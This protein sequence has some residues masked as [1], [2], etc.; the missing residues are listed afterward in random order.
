MLPQ[1]AV[2]G[3]TQTV[4]FKRE[5]PKQASDLAKEIAAFAT[6]NAGMILLGVEDDGEIV[7]VPEALDDVG[8]RT[9]RTRLEGIFNIVRPTIAPGIRFALFEGKAVA[10]IEVPKGPQ[11]IYYANS[12]P[13]HRLLTAARPMF[14]DDVI[15]AVLSWA[16]ERESGPSPESLF[17]GELA[18]F[19]PQVD[20]TVTERQLPQLN[21]WA[22][23]LRWTA[24]QQADQARQLAASAPVEMEALREPLLNLAAA[25]NTIAT[26]R[27]R[28]GAPDLDVLQAVHDAEQIVARVQASYLGLGRFSASIAKQQRTSLTTQARL[29]DDLVRRID[30]SSGSISAK[31]VQDETHQRGETLFLVASLGVGIG[32]EAKRRELREIAIEL[33]AI[34]QL[35]IY[36]DGGRSTERIFTAA[37]DCRARLQAWGSTLT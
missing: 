22:E 19:W 23:N 12:V 32:D 2:G 36:M 1:L 16:A 28:L 27:R 10:A 13:Y 20:L 3:E 24:G 37:R 4:E 5:F 7:G 18:G 9:L 6:S 14:P 15:E 25:L 34:A 35:S 26:E 33:R 31:I 17:L 21:P 29:L 8:R 30:A 11:P